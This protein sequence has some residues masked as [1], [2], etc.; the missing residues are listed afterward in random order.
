MSFEGLAWIELALLAMALC[1]WLR[2]RAGSR[3]TLSFVLALGVVAFA[4]AAPWLAVRNRLEPAAG[5]TSSSPA[6]AGRLEPVEP[7]G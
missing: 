2:S 3:R 1:A 4:L 5:P 7:A 6:A